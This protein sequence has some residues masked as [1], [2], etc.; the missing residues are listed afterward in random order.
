VY[1]NTKS[2]VVGEIPADVVGIVVDH[3]IIVVPIP[4][5]YVPQVEWSDAEEVSTEPEAIR[6]TAS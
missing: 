3:N 5:V 1:I 6:A 2:H 4:V